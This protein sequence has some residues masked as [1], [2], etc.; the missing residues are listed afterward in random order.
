MFTWPA[1]KNN[2]GICFF[3][4][5]FSSLVLL[6]A[7]NLTSHKEMK[8]NFQLN[9]HCL[10]MEFSSTLILFILLNQWWGNEFI[11]PII[12]FRYTIAWDFYV[13]QAIF[14]SKAVVLC[15]WSMRSADR[16]SHHS[17]HFSGFA[18]V[19]LNIGGRGHRLDFSENRLRQRCAGSS[20]TEQ[21][22]RSSTIERGQKCLIRGSAESPGRSFAGMSLQSYLKP[23]KWGELLFPTV[24]SH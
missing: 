4:S 7:F 9:L 6:W 24:M 3:P 5:W 10:T 11:C 2:V 18:T 14:Y 20:C 16:F 1:I 21:R 12:G 13:W 19:S 17:L 8:G 23:R 15:G 22:N